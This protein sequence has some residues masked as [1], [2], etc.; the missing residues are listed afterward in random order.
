M[1]T[2]WA[3]QVFVCLALGKADL[4]SPSERETDSEKPV[5]GLQGR[6]VG[7]DFAE[8]GRKWGR[9]P[10]SGEPEVLRESCFN[11]GEARSREGAGKTVVLECSQ[12][13]EFG[14]LAH[15]AETG[16]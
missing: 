6:G 7:G 5:V 8:W 10:R 1:D 3:A 16:P 14:D 4:E 12:G 13:P 11:G 2:V 15:S 9:L